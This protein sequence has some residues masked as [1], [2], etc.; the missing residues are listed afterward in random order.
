M[1]SQL[2]AQPD[3]PR[4]QGAGR[5]K[6]GQGITDWA[7]CPCA[8]I[9]QRRAVAELLVD[10]RF[11]G[12]ARTMTLASFET[13]GRAGNEQALRVAKNFVEH[14]E[15]ACKKGWVL[16]FWGE[17]SAGK[18]H[19]ATAIAQACIKRY[20]ARP[21]LLNV[22]KMLQAERE[23]YN[24]RP[25]DTPLP[26]PIVQAMHADLL[27]L[28]DLGAQYERDSGAERVSWVMEQ[29]YL[30]LDERFMNNRPTIYT[31]NLAPGDL[32]RRMANEAGKRVLSR[33]ERAEVIPPIEVIAV[34][35]VN[36]QDN[37]DGNLLIAEPATERHRLSAA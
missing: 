24:Q 34:P 27:I 16:G 11:P 12:R 31:S 2:Y 18:T 15:T 9:G 1:D 32:K 30:I 8:L 6:I 3:C 22:P 13:G 36:R 37:A 17:P 21:Q 28:D 29:L 4:C 25:G 10:E 35:A 14:Y 23:R 20:L 7:V 26:S 19:L 5:V 33:L